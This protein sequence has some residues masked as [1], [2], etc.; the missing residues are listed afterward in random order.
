MFS[1]EL[2]KDEGKIKW[3][4]DARYGNLEEVLAS[5]RQARVD[6]EGRKGGSKAR[7][8]LVHVSEKLVFYS[9]VMDVMVQHYPEYTSLAW[10]AMKFVFLVSPNV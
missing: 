8:A 10:G 3:I 5:V 1:S 2:T 9:G 7:E 6:Y 4:K